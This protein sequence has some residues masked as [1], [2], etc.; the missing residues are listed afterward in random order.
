MKL[1]NKVK[2]EERFPFSPFEESQQKTRKKMF[3]M[4]A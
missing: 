3:A 1:A 2:L 4:L